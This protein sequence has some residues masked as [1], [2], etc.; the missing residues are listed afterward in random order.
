MAYLNGV[1]KR[2]GALDRVCVLLENIIQ[3]DNFCSINHEDGTYS[4]T[5]IS[6]GGHY[7]GNTVL[8]YE[9]NKTVIDS[10]VVLQWTRTIREIE[11]LV[12]DNDI[13]LSSSEKEI[14]NK[15]HKYFTGPKGEY[16]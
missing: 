9:T 14:L 3:A 8:L 11:T 6:N 1:E 13:I 5:C 7:H 2:Q 4:V 12:K 16:I 15:I 10:M